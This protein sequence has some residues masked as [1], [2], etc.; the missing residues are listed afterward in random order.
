VFA[1]PNSIFGVGSVACSFQPGTVYAIDTATRCN[2][3]WQFL[4]WGLSRKQERIGHLGLFGRPASGD[5]IDCASEDPL[6]KHVGSR[7]IRLATTWTGQHHHSDDYR[8][9][10]E[11]AVFP[12]NRI[13]GSET[14]LVRSD[15]VLLVN[16]TGGIVF[17]VGSMDWVNIVQDLFVGEH[18]KE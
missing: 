3:D 18:T 1:A 12:M 16:D 4:F 2:L 14:H 9:F 6:G 5:E 11:E 13:K 17:S 7:L 10:P 8:L 15:I